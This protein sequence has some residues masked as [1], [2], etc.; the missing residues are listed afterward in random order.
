MNIDS[1]LDELERQVDSPNVISTPNK[2][3]PSSLPNQTPQNNPD[4]NIISSSSD[5]EL[6]TYDQVK[7]VITSAKTDQHSEEIQKSNK[8]EIHVAETVTETND[9]ISFDELDFSRE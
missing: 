7:S 2:P 5:E 8:T 1:L 9:L 3:L 4:N 6:P